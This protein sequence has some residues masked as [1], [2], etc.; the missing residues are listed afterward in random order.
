LGQISE[1]DSVGTPVVF[2]VGGS[3]LSN[4]GFVHRK[5]WEDLGFGQRGG[6]EQI[7]EEV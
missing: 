6:W 3:K 4:L 2:T 1:G 5:G 7:I